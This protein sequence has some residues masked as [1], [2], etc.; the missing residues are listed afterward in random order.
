VAS[1]LAGDLTK[2]SQTKAVVAIVMTRPANALTRRQLIF[3]LFF[4]P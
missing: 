3:R 1:A 4:I 2:L